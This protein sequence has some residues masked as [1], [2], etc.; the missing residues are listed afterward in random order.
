MLHIFTTKEKEI[1][2]RV[3]K[4]NGVEH[5][6]AVCI[7]ELNELLYAVYDYVNNGIEENLCEELADVEIVLYELILSRVCTPQHCS[8]NHS[9]A[10]HALND[11]IHD[12]TRWLRC[13]EIYTMQV[14]MNDVYEAV[15]LLKEEHTPKKVEEY[16]QLKLERLRKVYNV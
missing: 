4:F 5:Q 2:M 9:D 7:E 13:E 15:K 1:L 6:V 16:I 3:I 10:I 11:F 12:L 14:H 8:F